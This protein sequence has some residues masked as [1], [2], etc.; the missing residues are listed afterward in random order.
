[1]LFD[2]EFERARFVWGDESVSRLD[3]LLAADARVMVV[4]GEHVGATPSVMDPVRAAIGERLVETY[5][6]ARPN[7]P[8]E[9]VT[10][11]VSRLEASGADALVSVG[12][13]SASDTAKAIAIFAGEETDDLDQLRTHTVDGE[14]TVPD[15]PAA[16]VPLYCVVTTLSAAEVTNICGV[17]TPEEK[18]VLLDEKVRPQACLYDPTVAATTPDA[19]IASTGMNAL[20][21]AVEILYSEGRSDNPFYQATAEKAI[22]LLTENL[23]G[24]VSGDAD[25]RV[26]TQLGAALSGLGVVGGVSINHGVNHILCARHPLSH[27]DGNSILLPHGVRFTAPEA[28]EAIRRIA[29]AMGVDATGTDDEVVDAVVDAIATLQETLGTPTR[30]RDVGVDRDDFEAVAA[31]A[32]GEPSL[33]SSP[34]DITEAD[35]VSFLDAAW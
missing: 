2:H 31:I 14:V 19:V 3:D 6:G 23:P 18:V 33:A 7:V 8:H 12:G 21:H 28:P 24:A 32:V 1:M 26:Q 17:S 5:T 16:K 27:G 20:D 13:G 34:R 25:A 30:L 4:T 9:T 35:I 10:E 15:L 11:G 29:R 22:R